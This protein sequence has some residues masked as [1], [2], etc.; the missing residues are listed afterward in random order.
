MRE[1]CVQSRL[2]REREALF[3]VML[4][5]IIVF[6]R[7]QKG[8][9]HFLELKRCRGH[10]VTQCHRLTE[11]HQICFINISAIPPT[12]CRLHQCHYDLILGLEI[13][14]KTHH[15]WE[16]FCKKKKKFFVSV[17]CSIY[18]F[19]FKG[20]KSFKRRDFHIRVLSHWSLPN[21]VNTCSLLGQIACG[22]VTS[23]KCYLDSKSKSTA[24]IFPTEL[25]LQI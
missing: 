24:I 8:M 9:K 13:L 6:L 4:R 22:F 16:A 5:N 15:K 25:I 23:V 2:E 1:D 17:S 14:C 19:F 3:S 18:N 11:A 10:G 21:G 7:V 12:Q 20:F